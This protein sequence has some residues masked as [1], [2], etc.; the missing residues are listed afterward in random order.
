MGKPVRCIILIKEI[1]MSLEMI[2]D[3]PKE[4]RTTILDNLHNSVKKRIFD[5]IPTLTDDLNL[6][7][8]SDYNERVRLRREYI[9]KYPNEKHWDYMEY[10]PCKLYNK[11]TKREQLLLPNVKISTHGDVIYYHGANKRVFLSLNEDF[12]NPTY[13]RVKINRNKY[14]VHRLVGCLYCPIPDHLK[15]KNIEE[16]ITNHIDLVKSNDMYSNIEWVTNGENVK[17]SF[18]KEPL[19]GKKGRKTGENYYSDKYI[20]MEVVANNQFKGRKYVINGLEQCESAGFKWPSLRYVIDGSKS[21]NYGHKASY[22]GV[23]EAEKYP[24][25][26]PEDIK[27]L[28]DTDHRYFAVDII[29]SIGTI[30][31]GPFK[32]HQ[33]SLFGAAEQNKYFKQ[34]NIQK[35]INGE[36]KSSGKCHWRKGTL[37][38]GIKFH[39]R[40]TDEIYK[41]LQ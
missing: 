9:D 3:L 34:A 30:L 25:G 17:Y 23:E 1:L 11:E 7:E 6:K 32:G 14:A 15:D 19:I 24:L 2:I 27:T 36:R 16:L 40:L 13:N 5:K 37:M 38:E 10:Y 18:N 26:M 31:E 33:F 28:F 4:I 21:Q 41:T 29:P 12:N 8:I 22:I 39:N 20:L 35:V